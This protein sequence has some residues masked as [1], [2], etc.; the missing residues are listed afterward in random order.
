MEKELL[1]VGEAAE[2]LSIGR[3]K[4]YELI[5]GGVIPVVRIGRAVRV[6]ARALPSLVR[7]LQDE[8][9]REDGGR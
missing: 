9:T 1:T 3:T 6:P 8:R 2:A 4:T 7:R 5:A